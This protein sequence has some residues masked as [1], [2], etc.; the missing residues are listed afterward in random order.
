MSPDLSQFS[1][2]DLF[3]LEVEGQ[4][5]VLT[6]GLLALEREPE[7]AAQ[8]EACMRAAHSLKGAAR[9][10]G[11]NAAVV[12]AHAMEDGFVAAQRGR[13]RIG[14][15]HIDLMLRGLDLLVQ[16]A[17]T[18]E[19]EAASWQDAEAPAAQAFVADLTAALAAP[20]PAPAEVAPA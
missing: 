20:A 9:I 18:P 3:R 1:M 15:A 4:R 16:I 10:V 13:L 5:E 19:A 8:L 11:L 7:A 6:A 14:Q 17:N 12:V 2:H